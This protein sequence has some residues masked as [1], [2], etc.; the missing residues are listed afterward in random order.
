VKGGLIAYSTLYRLRLIQSSRRLA[1][2][3]SRWEPSSCSRGRTPWLRPLTAARRSLTMPRRGSPPRGRA[4]CFPASRPAVWPRACR[5]LKPPRRRSGYMGRRALPLALGSSQRICPRSSPQ[6]IG[7]C[8]IDWPLS[9]E[10]ILDGPQFTLMPAAF[11]SCVL[12]SISRR[13]SASNCSEVKGIGSAPSSL[14]FWR[15]A[16]CASALATSPCNRARISAEVFIGANTPAQKLYSEFG[17]PAST[18]VGTCRR[19]DARVEP[20]TASA[21]SWPSLSR[22]N[23]LIKGAK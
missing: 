9:G 22:G 1:G 12:V 16:G 21:C 17:Y 13:T 14:S 5:D 8:L 10:L 18:V 7:S 19:A 15:M 4:T 2:R 20:L 3:H 23:A 11:T 6:Y